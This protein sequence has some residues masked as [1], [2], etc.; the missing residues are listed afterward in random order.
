MNLI[1]LQAK[2]EERFA[3]KHK[4][5]STRY[6]PIAPRSKEG[7]GISE[8]NSRGMCAKRIKVGKMQGAV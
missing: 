8:K 3:K 5:C 7:N 6:I 4:K 1:K 2:Y